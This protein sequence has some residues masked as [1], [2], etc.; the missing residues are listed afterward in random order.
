MDGGFIK[1]WRQ[2]LDSEVFADADLFKL[3]A[4]CLMSAQW[5]DG[6]GKNP[7]KRGQLR[8]TRALAAEA[9]RI[10][11]SKFY[12]GLMRLVDMGCVTVEANS[13]WTTITVCNYS[14]YQD[15]D[16]ISEQQVNSDRTASEQRVNSDPKTPLEEE[17]EE[18][19][20]KERRRE[21]PQES[22]VAKDAA[23]D[24]HDD[25]LS[26]ARLARKWV[27]CRKGTSGRSELDRARTTFEEMIRLGCDAAQIGAEI[28]SFKRRRTEPIWD[29]EERFLKAAGL[30][31]GKSTDS[32]K[33][34]GIYDGLARFAGRGN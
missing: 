9:L 13:V 23:D 24:D 32:K 2:T 3:F 8:T 1:L 20:K 29:F 21:A 4:W 11:G 15:T 19:G 33:A 28:E 16:E 6:R 27:F 22:P 7:L 14:T 17:E 26:P 18:E 25:P 12:R 5:K 30:W 10:S 34:G 31:T